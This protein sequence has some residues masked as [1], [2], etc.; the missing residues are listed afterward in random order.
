[1]LVALIATALCQAAWSVADVNL[2]KQLDSLTQSVREL[3]SQQVTFQLGVSEFYRHSYS[4]GVLSVRNSWFGRSSYDSAHSSSTGFLAAHDH[5]NDE[6]TVGLGEFS[7]ILNGIPFKTRHNDY[8]LFMRTDP[9]APNRPGVRMWNQRAKIPFPPV[10]QQVKD[11]DQKNLTHAIEIMR[12]YFRAWMSNGDPAALNSYPYDANV[13][14]YP[15]YFKANLVVLEGYF[16]PKISGIDPADKFSNRHN[17]EAKSYEDLRDKISFA[18]LAGT[19]DP[20]ENLAFLPSQ[21]LE[22]STTESGVP[23]GRIGQFSYQIFAQP[24][25]GH[26]PLNVIF[27]REDLS[28]RTRYANLNK[29]PLTMEQHAADRTARFILNT[30]NRSKMAPGRKLALLLD[31]LM[32][33]VPGPDGPDVVLRWNEFGDIAETVN[34]LGGAPLNTARYHRALRF[35]RADAMGIS[36]M[37]KADHDHNVFMAMTTFTD[38]V[39]AITRNWTSGGKTQ[40]M[41]VATTWALPLEIVYHTPLSGWNP[42]RIPRITID[43]VNVA[44]AAGNNGKLNTSALPGF[45][46][47]TYYLTPLEF[48]GSISASGDPADTAAPYLWFNDSKGV[49]RRTVASGTWINLP[50]IA[51][52]TPSR[53]VTGEL[54]GPRLRFPI[55]PDA[56]EGLSTRKMA[57]A[58][59]D[60]IFQMDQYTELLRAAD[61]TILA[62]TN[63]T[64]LRAARKDQST[65]ATLTMGLSVPGPVDPHVHTVELLPYQVDQLAAGQEIQVTSSQDNGHNHVLTIFKDTNSGKIV[66]RRCDGSNALCFD[67]HPVELSIL[68]GLIQEPGTIPDAAQ[69]PSNWHPSE[70]PT[71][72]TVTVQH[73]TALLRVAALEGEVG[74]L[75]SLLHAVLIANGVIVLLIVLIGIV[76]TVRAATTSRRPAPTTTATARKRVQMDAVN[77]DSMLTH[78]D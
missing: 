36:S 30:A 11:F 23:I 14:D 13:S 16:T 3:M 72:T 70:L 55:V 20:G 52:I 5:S 15:Q 66:Y 42:Y 62:A 67:E 6:A 37:A 32:Y 25:A 2:K 56:E 18:S 49:P 39:V 28:T 27:P 71:D 8:R 4:S 40:E 51:G 9:V 19:K 59:A 38:Q 7:A 68:S 60:A 61:D 47:T 24:I 63:V 17:I 44:T 10:P 69:A 45:S 26:L 64:A 50:R 78:S 53:T 12:K 34:E 1:M 75:R 46:E 35:Q 21:L 22:Y 74:E 57:D 77:A 41:S 76:S 33:Q 58:M 73:A 43:A 48:F 65:S 29:P 54:R 31:E